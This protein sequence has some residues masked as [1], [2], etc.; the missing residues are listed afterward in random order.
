MK[1]KSIVTAVM[2]AGAFGAGATTVSESG[3]MTFDKGEQL[4]RIN[5]IQNKGKMAKSAF[6]G[7][8]GQKAIQNEYLAEKSHQGTKLYI[9][10]LVDDAVTSYKGGIKG[11]SATKSSSKKASLS[12]A[13]FEAKSKDAVKYASYLEQKQNEF[14]QKASSKI[15]GAMPKLRSLKYAINGLVTELTYEDALKVAKMPE[16]AFIEQNERIALNTDTGPEFIGAGEVWD[17]TANGTEYMGEGIVIGVL[18]TGVNTD[19]RSFAAT[20]DDGYT[21]VNPLGEGVY[22]GDCEEDASLCNSKLIGVRSYEALLTSSDWGDLTPPTNGEDHHGHGSHTSSTAGGNVLL[23]VPYTVS[24]PSSG[25]T[26]DG[27]ETDLVFPRMSGVAPHAN[28]ISYQTCLPGNSGDTASGCF[29][30]SALGAIDDAIADGVDVI[31]YSVGGNTPFNPWTSATEIGFLNASAAGIFVATSAGNSGPGASTVTKASPWY[32]AVGAVYH[33]RW[34][35]DSV[36]PPEEVSFPGDVM[37]GF[38]SR[39]PNAFGQII[40]P[41]ISAPGGYIYAAYSDDQPYMDNSGPTPADFTMMSGTSMASPHIAGT[42]ALIM[43]AHPTWN[44]DQVRSALMMTATS[45]ILKEDFATPADHFDTGAGRVQVN[46]AI[47]AG[48]IM[49]ET[50]ENYAAADPAAGGNPRALNIPSI[51]NYGCAETSRPVKSRRVIIFT[52]PAT[53]SAP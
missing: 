7:F 45:A 29:S 21:A 19:H 39:G 47:N 36:T 6:S 34:V 35:D 32:T 10:R 18:D 31:N 23:D 41:Q 11:L 37:T 44:P 4:S 40:T 2:M 3:M 49:S 50:A 8:P 52:T 16:V 43:Q 1:I 53:A 38:S 33:G 20:G 42:A 12:D 30:A 15:K 28:I 27:I 17:G 22:K 24:D 9:V 5:V 13:K 26:G 48:L 51:A 46:E 25:T 14:V